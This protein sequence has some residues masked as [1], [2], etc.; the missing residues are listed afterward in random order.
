MEVSL[1]TTTNYLSKHNL[2]KLLDVIIL[3][4]I[5]ILILPPFR[6]TACTTWNTRAFLLLPGKILLVPRRKN[7]DR[8][9]ND[10][11]FGKTTIKFGR[12]PRKPVENLCTAVKTHENLVIPLI[13]LV[14][15]ELVLVLPNRCAVLPSNQAMLHL[16]HF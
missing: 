4:V 16:W 9:K 13:G 8:G 2:I 3:L 14:I 1:I 12:Q 15:P 5:Q 7:L 11:K 6:M 10:K